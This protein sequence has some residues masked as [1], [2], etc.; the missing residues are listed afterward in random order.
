MADNGG[1]AEATPYDE[2]AQIQVRFITKDSAVEVPAVPISVPMRLDSN[3][4]SEIIN[5]LAEGGEEDDDLIEDEKDMDEGD[6]KTKLK[7]R[8]DFLIQG[9]FLR[10]TLAAYALQ[11]RKANDPV[12]EKGLVIEYTEAMPP[13]QTGPT[14]TH[15]DWVSALHSCAGSGDEESASDPVLSLVSGCYDGV[16]R[17]YDGPDSTKSKGLDSPSAVANTVAAHAKPI[18]AVIGFLPRKGNRNGTLLAA[19]GSQDHTVRVWAREKGEGGQGLTASSDGKRSEAPA[20]MAPFALLSGHLGSVE[21]LAVMP[22][23]ERDRLLSGGFDS[24]LLVWR[25]PQVDADPEDNEERKEGGKGPK[26]RRGTDGAG[27]DD[28]GAFRHRID[29][30]MTRL[31]GATGPVTGVAWPHPV[32]VYATGWDRQVR[33]WDIKTGVNALTLP[34]KAAGTSLSFGVGANL[35]ATGHTDK[36][37][38]LWDPRQNEKSVMKMQLKSHSNFVTSVRWCKGNSHKLASSSNDGSVKI[39]DVRAKD[40][41]HSLK[42]HNGKALCVEWWGPGMLT[43]GGTD[44]RINAR[45]LTLK[46]KE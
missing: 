16:V 8:F 46:K 23:P 44:N 36:T 28:R 15:P 5:A 29:E 31:E 1:G 38:C 43:S 41:L 7:R 4:L 6:S 22:T 10:T 19:S 42:T 24:S 14:A 13:P 25:L 9:V 21:C 26:R 45:I 30:P 33:M 2:N 17:L 20:V 39:W 11:R 40:P 37:I 35:I 34:A 18:K 32:A 27:I 12:D 3:G